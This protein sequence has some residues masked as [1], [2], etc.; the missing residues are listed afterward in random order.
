MAN[1][2]HVR[3]VLKHLLLCIYIEKE[4]NLSITLYDLNIFFENQI[5]LPPL[6]WAQNGGRRLNVKIRLSKSIELPNF[7]L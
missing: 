6:I 2:S 1:H 4:F 3:V 5:F 7:L